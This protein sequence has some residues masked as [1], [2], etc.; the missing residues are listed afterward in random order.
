MPTYYTGVPANIT[1]PG[2]NIVIGATNAS[3]IV[4]TTNTAHN[5][6]TGDTVL[7]AFVAG[8][9]AANSQPNNPWVITVI[10]ATHFALY[11]ANGVPS[12]GN[13]AFSGDGFCFD[14]SLIPPYQ[15]P[16]DGDAFNASA[17]NVAFQAL[18]DRTQLLQAKQPSMYLLADY[19]S[20]VGDDGWFSWSSGTSTSGAWTEA[21]NG[22]IIDFSF[23]P[24][25]PVCNNGDQFLITANTSVQAG[26][27]SVAFAPGVKCAG[28]AG[29]AL[30]IPAGS[31]TH[32]DPSATLPWQA[33]TLLQINSSGVLA[34]ISAPVSGVQIV[35]GLT[36]MSSS[37]LGAD[38][39]I[40]GFFAPADPQ[41]T[42]TFPITQWISPSSVKIANPGGVLDSHN[43]TGIQWEGVN[44]PFQLFFCVY[45]VGGASTYAAYGHR[46]MI[47][48]HYRP[49]FGLIL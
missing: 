47:V 28:M 49:T 24:P 14:Y 1:T 12:T 4:C 21:N 15:I 45:G 36:G 9:T 3:P 22:M 32:Y 13:G 44:M 7:V 48:Y 10:D 8:N 38:L 25:V 6:V 2:A 37:M 39:R 19:L 18:G 41:N 27:G 42:G 33:N 26:S 20:G 35:T 31:A 17:F 40:G 23:F 16:S 30:Q 34:Q 29:N 43:G 46:E 5:Y 11:F